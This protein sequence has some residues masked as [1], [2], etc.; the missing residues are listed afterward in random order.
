MYCRI[1]R[2]EPLVPV[3]D[4]G[5]QYVSDFVDKENIQKGDLFPMTVGVNPKTTLGQLFHNYPP[6]RMY[7]TY[8]YNS[9]TNESMRKE[10]KSIVDSVSDYVTLKGGDTVLDIASNSGEMLT[11][12]P[13]TVNRI[14]IDP[15]D[16]ARDSE[17]YKKEGIILINDYFSSSAFK[18]RCNAKPKV[19]SLI[20]MF[21]DL[22]DPIGI[23]REIRDVIA[24]DGLFILQMSYTPLMLEQNG[25]DNIGHEHLC[26]YSLESLEQVLYR[27]G[28]TVVDV[29]LNPT[30]GGSFRVYCIPK[31]RHN[32]SVWGYTD[33]YILMTN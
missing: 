33:R 22:D 2:N 24:E 29:K 18:A 7:K 11:S 23:T 27:S 16:V 15:S 14:G 9:S 1:N 13:R 17:I 8:W 25:F 21:Y 4:L 28:F 31:E 20:A 30:N 12:Y 6:E 19:I 3:L 10:L 5:S 26:Y 32:P